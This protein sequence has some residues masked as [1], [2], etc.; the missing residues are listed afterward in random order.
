MPIDYRGVGDFMVIRWGDFST[1]LQL[2]I[3]ALESAL[4]TVRSNGMSGVVLDL[5]GNSGG[6]V[7]LYLAMASY[8]FTEDNPMPV[9]PFD[10]YEYDAD[11]GDQVLAP[12]SEQVVSSPSATS[13]YTGPVTILI[14]ERCASACEY[15]SQHLQSLGRATIVGQFAS[16]GAG[17]PVEQVTLPQDTYFT[18]TKGRTT[19]A[20]TEEPNLEGKGVIP[21]VRVPVTLATELAKTRGEDPV[22]DAAIAE[23]NRMVAASASPETVE[24][25]SGEVEAVR[26][27]AQSEKPDYVIDLEAAYGEPSQAAFGSAV[28]FE[29]LAADADL[30]TAA[31]KW[32][33]HFVGDLWEKYGEDAWMGPW[34][35]VYTRQ[36][37]G[38]RDVVA[39]LGGI[40]GQPIA[41]SVDMILNGVENPDQ[42]R[43]ALAAAADDPTVTELAAYS[44]GDGE[45]MSG[46]LVAMRRGESGETTFLTFLLD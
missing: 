46:I 37:D 18:Y 12:K 41:S 29:K 39:E 31:R 7:E 45:A 2:K 3:A 32:Y 30:E 19:F 42:A 20:G 23:M 8:F 5:R 22:L 35:T 15:F 44:L 9:S 11:V 17:G 14:D 40:T 6:L 24:S 43:R 28:F 13:A 21:D 10:W 25:L 38:K 26:S 34:S 16:K 1:A 33:R 4:E 36:S 27:E